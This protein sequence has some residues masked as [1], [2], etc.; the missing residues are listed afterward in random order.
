MPVS[1]V[2]NWRKEFNVWSEGDFNIFIFHSLTK[3]QRTDILDQY[4]QEGGVLLTTYGTISSQIDLFTDSYVKDGYQFDYI[5][6]D[7]GHKLKNPSTLLSKCLHKLPSTMCRIVISG[8]PVQNNLMEMHAL[9][10]W[11]FKG[12]L[13]G[14]RKTF[15]DE[16][17]KKIVRANEKDATSF[18][19]KLGAEILRRFREVISPHML[20]REKS[21]VLQR[22]QP[23]DANNLRKSIGGSLQKKISK[24]NDLVIWIKSTNYQLELYREFL[25]SEDV[26]EVIHES[27]SPL[28]GKLLFQIN[29]IYNN[30]SHYNFEA[31]MLPS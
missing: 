19:Q 30:P 20:R 18:E 4:K 23:A 7:E 27:T 22:I 13:L 6:L 8:T 3:K 21:Q 24:K 26:H 29:S 11:I 5:I 15:K 2:E 16:F 14:D 25:K 28:A 17:E 1:L 12:T 10:D 9:M 31:N